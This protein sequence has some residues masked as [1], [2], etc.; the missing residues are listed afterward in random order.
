M[1]NKKVR[2]LRKLSKNKEHYKALKR[3]YYNLSED[4]KT[5]IKES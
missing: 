2:A 4:K 3:A 1:R 5:K